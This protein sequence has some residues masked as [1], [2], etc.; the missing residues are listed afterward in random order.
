MAGAR[1][2]NHRLMKKRKPGRLRL[3]RRRAA[4]HMKRQQAAPIRRASWMP[5]LVVVSCIFVSMALAVADIQVRDVKARKIAAYVA[6]VAALF[7]ASMSGLKLMKLLLPG[8]ASRTG[9][10]R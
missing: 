5:Y 10:G 1:P 8:L 3:A 6:A 7:L 2:R 9:P 4:A